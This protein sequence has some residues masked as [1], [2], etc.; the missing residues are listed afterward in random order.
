MSATS[1]PLGDPMAEAYD[2][3]DDGVE[4]V[5]P[6][7]ETLAKD[8][9]SAPTVNVPKVETSES[10]LKKAEEKVEEGTKA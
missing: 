5:G 9:T 3:V 10:P 8:E 4:D 7:G 2:Y 6:K 1:G